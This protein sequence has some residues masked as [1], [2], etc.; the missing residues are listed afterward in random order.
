MIDAIEVAHATGINNLLAEQLG[1]LQSREGILMNGSPYNQV[2]PGEVPPNRAGVSVPIGN[3][4]GSLSNKLGN[5]FTRGWLAGAG[6]ADIEH[7]LGSTAFD[8]RPA[9]YN[10]RTFADFR[11][12]VPEYGAPVAGLANW[13]REAPGRTF[14]PLQE[15]RAEYIPTTWSNKMAGLDPVSGNVGPRVATAKQGILSAP[16]PA[17]FAYEQVRE[18][19]DGF[20]SYP[21]GTR[22]SNPK[23]KASQK[24]G[25]GQFVS[26]AIRGSG[27]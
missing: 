24:L 21:F 25:R 27:M 13:D 16:T 1:P 11:A 19:G 5:K 18:G 12:V 22:P 9:N 10:C 14:G 7:G 23:I 4:A 26:G 8:V 15:A 17:Y 20:P 6:G 2:P 3:T